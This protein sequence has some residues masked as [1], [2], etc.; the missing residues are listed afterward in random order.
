MGKIEKLDTEGIQ[1]ARRFLVD[2]PI[3]HSFRYRDGKILRNMKELY[4][5]F[6]V[7]TDETYVFHHNKEKNDFSNWVRDI[8]GD[9]KLAKDLNGQHAL[10]LRHGK[11]LPEWPI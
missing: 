5:A 11:L 10:I 7:M 1:E 3:E 2:V 4:D 8:I 6:S 9:T